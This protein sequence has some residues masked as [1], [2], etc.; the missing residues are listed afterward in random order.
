MRVA[1][2]GPRRAAVRIVA[3]GA[4]MPLHLAH[5]PSFVAAD[6]STFALAARDAALLAWLALEGSTQ[7]ARLAALLWP[8][9]EPETARNSLRQRLFQLKKQ[10]GVTLVSGSST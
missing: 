5:S 3:T 2:S 8:D 10:L 9:S 6:G 4:A 1:T 7:R